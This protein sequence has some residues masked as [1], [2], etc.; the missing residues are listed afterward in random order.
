MNDQEAREFVEML[1]VP[2]SPAPPLCPICGRA[3]PLETQCLNAIAF[4]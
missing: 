3:H 1:A 2:E 4:K